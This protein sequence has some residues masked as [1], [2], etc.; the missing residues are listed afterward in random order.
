MARFT[1][2]S[3]SLVGLPAIMAQTTAPVYSPTTASPTFAPTFSVAVVENSVESDFANIVIECATESTFDT[4]S[5]TVA[6]SNIVGTTA[7]W[8]IGSEANI[9][10][11]EIA[12]CLNEAQTDVLE[13][14]AAR[15][16]RSLLIVGLTLLDVDTECVL[17][18]ACPADFADANFCYD[19]TS[20]ILIQNGV[21]LITSSPTSSPTVKSGK[22]SSSGS[23]SGK[24]SSS[25]SKS[26]KGDAPTVSSGSKS[27]KGGKTGKN[28]IRV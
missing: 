4:T 23:K 1:F 26:G 19:C 12:A 6:G 5:A 18:D 16:R 9:P 21:D 10:P 2:A 20:E 13:T 27:G 7:T 15:T 24:G 11:T 22:G 25:G 17:I 28:R 14:R 3:L 8:T